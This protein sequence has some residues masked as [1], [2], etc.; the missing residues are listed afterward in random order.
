MNL[1]AAVARGESRTK[2]VWWKSP[3]NISILGLAVTGFLLYQLTRSTILSAPF[4]A[5]L[6]LSIQGF[7]WMGG[8]ELVSLTGYDGLLYVAGLHAVFALLLFGLFCHYSLRIWNVPARIAIFFT[9]SFF[10]LYLID[11]LASTREH[12][13]FVLVNWAVYTF[14]MFLSLLFIQNRNAVFTIVKV[15][16]FAIGVQAL[17]AIIF[18]IQGINQ[19]ETP[20][21]G[22]R[23]GGTLGTPNQLY[24]LVMIG[25]PLTIAIAWGQE[26]RFRKGF[27]LFLACLTIFALI[28][29]FTRTGWI[30]LSFGLLCFLFVRPAVE[31]PLTHRLALGGL[32][33][34]L[35]LSA[36]LVRTQGAWVGNENDRSFWGRPAIWITAVSIVKD[37]PLIG[38]GVG[39]YGDLQ[40]AKAG[41]DLL[42]FNPMND[43]PKNLMIH[44]I[45]ELGIIGL[46]IFL[47]LIWAVV[48]VIK[49]GLSHANLAYE[50]RL[51]FQG[52]SFALLTLIIAGIADTPILHF[53]RWESTL[54]T[55]ALLGAL[56]VIQNDSK[57]PNKLDLN[58]VRIR[59]RRFFLAALLALGIFLTAS[60]IVVIP[61]LSKVNHLKVSNALRNDYLAQNKDYTRLNHIPP[62]L[63]EAM[64][65]SEDG[66]FFYHQGVDWNAL[67]RSLRKN[68]RSMT[69]AQG[70]STITMQSARYVWLGREKTVARK[71]AEILL[72][73]ELEKRLTKQEIL[74]LYFNSARFGLG[75]YSIASASHLYFAKSPMELNE[76][77]I[78]FLAGVLPEPPAHENEIT[79]EF[80]RHCQMRAFT[81]WQAMYGHT[82]QTKRIEAKLKENLAFDFGR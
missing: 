43:E 39:T 53:A 62:L 38:F 20:H 66:N 47:G 15:I 68:V 65:A 57:S 16:A 34:G 50:H 69:L 70:G 55:F 52:I 81:R 45:T 7:L 25:V 60:A 28:L 67:H 9:V 11:F 26:N 41:P 4:E 33:L 10:S 46:G 35:L 80:A 42:R 31:S 73:L 6:H 79:P 77:E 51:I 49:R 2:Y 5:L 18:Y 61:S 76:P 8:A 56:V 48:R 14:I 13:E 59:E 21:F 1:D 44:V 30:A 64:I 24:P 32:C 58:L 37:S 78:M 82:S 3:I 12:Y 23:T 63:Q 72:A 71:F 19:F 40:K 27:W 74:E 54:T 36:A 22:H 17:Y 75:A 29:T